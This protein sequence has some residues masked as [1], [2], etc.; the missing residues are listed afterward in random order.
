MKALGYLFSPR[1]NALCKEVKKKSKRILTFQPMSEHPNPHVRDTLGAHIVD[2]A[3][4]CIFLN[5]DKLKDIKEAEITAAEDLMYS[6]MLVEKFPTTFPRQSS[7]LLAVIIAGLLTSTIHHLTV[8][9]RLQERDFPIEIVEERERKD[10][11]EMLTNDSFREPQPG[12]PIFYDLIIGYTKAYFFHESHWSEIQACFQKRAPIICSLGDKGI[13][14]VKRYGCDTPKKCLNTLI[15][16][17]DLLGLQQR[18]FILNN[19]TG[20]TF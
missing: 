11:L 2:D 10:L 5:V 1:F 8:V 20:R 3:N 7:D 15:D 16:L 4:I 9:S 19:E 6:L 18:V 12:T 14:V 17:R 13:E